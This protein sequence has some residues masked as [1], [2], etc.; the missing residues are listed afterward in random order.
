MMPPCLGTECHRAPEL[1]DA[2]GHD[3]M[4]HRI[5]N[6]LVRDEREIA[7]LAEL[8][9][10]SDAELRDIRGIG[11]E[12]V[13]RIRDLVPYAP[14]AVA[15]P[16]ARMAEAVTPRVREALQWDFPHW[17][18]AL[19]R[20]GWWVADR[21]LWGTVYG[22]SAAQLR[23]RLRAV[24][25]ARG[26]GRRA[27]VLGGRGFLWLGLRVEVFPG[28]RPAHPTRNVRRASPAADATREQT[29]YL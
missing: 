1:A 26:A 12:C 21:A 27:S 5:V 29:R 28:P 18:I 16:D 2:L 14:R 10:V 23:K 19:E 9:R 7:T 6:A 13:D 22:E 20:S 25:A 8:E 11:V 15:A 24:T 4:G 17:V 3:R